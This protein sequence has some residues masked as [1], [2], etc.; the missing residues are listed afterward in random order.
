MIYSKSLIICDDL[1]IRQGEK[2]RKRKRE[3]A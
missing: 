3:S 1:A 2:K